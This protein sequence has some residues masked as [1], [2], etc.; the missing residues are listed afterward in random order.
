MILVTGASGNVG[1]A[2]LARLHADGVAARAAYRDPRATAEVTGSGGRAV[3]L[4]L[5]EPDTLGP[6]LQGVETVFLIGATGPDQTAHELNM[7]EAARAAGVRVVKLSVWRAD[8]GLSPIARLHRPVEEALVAS[9][10]PWTILRPNFY[11]QN[12]LRQSS[13]REAGEFMLPLITAPISFV[14]VGDIARAAARVLTGD[15]HDGRVYDLTG[16]EALTYAEAAEAFSGV[17]GRPVRYVGL[18]DHEAR[19]AMLSRGMP[20]FHVDA[21]IEVARAYRDGGAETVTSAVPDLTGRA[22]LGFADFVRENRRF[23]E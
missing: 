3:T 6:A 21:L 18:P 13:V 17:L 10:L 15:G 20:E 14:D 5:A 1:T 12:F 22:A 16:P 4:D 19:A 7:V 8:E 11:L 2:L 23:F 9:G